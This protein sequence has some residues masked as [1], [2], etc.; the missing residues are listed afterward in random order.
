MSNPISIRLDDVHL[1]L[2][3]KM[4]EKLKDEGIDKNRTDVIQMA[5]YLLSKEILG[6]EEVSDIIDKHYIG[7]K[8]WGKDVKKI[9][10]YKENDEFVIE[11]KTESN[12]VIKSSFKTE[13]DFK[14]WLDSNKF[15]IDEIDVEDE[16]LWPL[17][18]NHL[19]KGK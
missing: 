9:K 3:N 19:S 11:R 15:E 6:M 8:E 17:V 10:V 7:I 13:R 14:V 4:I 18:I 5:I 2:I 16:E 1:T 12:Q